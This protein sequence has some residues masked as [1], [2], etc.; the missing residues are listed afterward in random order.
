MVSSDDIQTWEAHGFL[1]SFM[2]AESVGTSN[3]F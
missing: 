1:T 3:V 2:I